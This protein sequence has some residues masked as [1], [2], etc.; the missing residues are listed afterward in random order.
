ME[1]LQ[2]FKTKLIMIAYY[3]VK[4]LKLISST[5]KIKIL[6]VT[7]FIR[8]CEVHFANKTFK[9]PRL[10]SIGIILIIQF[11]KLRSGK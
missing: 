9:F 7:F 3:E 5:D 8:G 1:E 6:N 2:Y 4:N 11:L 10:D